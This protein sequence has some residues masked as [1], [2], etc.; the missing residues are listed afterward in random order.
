MTTNSGLKGKVA[1]VTGANHGIGAETAKAL[2]REGVSVFLNYL[3]FKDK[4]T[5]K[6]SAE[7]LGEALYRK[8]QSLST[9]RIVN[10]IRKRGGKVEEWEADLADPTN[11]PQLFERAEKA[12]GLVNILV[13]N[14]AFASSDT[15]VPQ[16]E[17][18]KE[19]QSIGGFK[20]NPITSVSHDQHFAVNS[21]AVAL[22][23]AEF[24]QRH[25]KR[26]DNWG[27][28]INISTEGSP[29]FAAEV[30]YGASKNA[31]ESY[32]RAA[33]SEL[34]KYGI[35]VNIVS[36][37]PIQTGYITPELENKLKKEIPLGRVGEPEDVA[38]VVIFFASDQ[39]RFLTGQILYVGGGHRM[40]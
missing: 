11:I 16:S 15:F 34:G 8:R 33:A 20:L 40:I 23:M 21:R 35:T 24:A 12:F 38:E 30:S 32:S 2:A 14:A 25:I 28:I 3:R 5:S 31:L 1:I 9:R 39:A 13:N 37:G 36:P 7:I 27:R 10:E 26:K 22:L 19:D 17:L 29:G 18:R 6:P 4:E